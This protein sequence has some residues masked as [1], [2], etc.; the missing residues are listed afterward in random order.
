MYCLGCV[1]AFHHKHSFGL[2][3][4]DV[5][6]YQKRAVCVWDAT[7]TPQEVLLWVIECHVG[8]R[9]S[10]TRKVGEAA[11]DG[12]SLPPMNPLAQGW[13][14][15]SVSCCVAGVVVSSP[16]DGMNGENSSQAQSVVLHDTAVHP[17]CLKNTGKV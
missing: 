4:A 10:V 11:K 13:P 9:L 5:D 17:G 6:D 8:G 3:E 12:G 1:A 7:D 16:R 14:D 2:R 15:W